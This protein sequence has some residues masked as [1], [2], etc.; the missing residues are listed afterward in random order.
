[1]PT[2]ATEQTT[3]ADIELTDQ[4]RAELTLNLRTYASLLAEMDDLQESIE[5]QKSELAR[6]R[7]KLGVKSIG[8]EGV[9]RTT[10]VSGGTTKRFDKKKQRKYLLVHDVPPHLEHVPSQWPHRQA[11]GLR[12]G[13]GHHRRLHPRAVRRPQLAVAGV[14]GGIR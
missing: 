13:R 2:L 7:E 9:G 10:L 11:R 1:M 3:E 14:P 8:V 5:A 12:G 4:Q 6:V